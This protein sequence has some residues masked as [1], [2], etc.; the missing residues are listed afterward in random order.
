MQNTPVAANISGFLKYL[1]PARIDDILLN[2]KIR[3][4]QPLALN[5]PLEF[6]P[7]LTGFS[8]HDYYDF[9]I[10]GIPMPST[11]SWIRWRLVNIS[12]RSFGILSLTKHPTSFNMWSHYADGHKGFIIEL[13]SEFNTHPTFRA[14][15]GHIYPIKPVEYQDRFE[16]NI[17][18]MD[19]GSGFVDNNKFYDKLCFTKCNRW[20]D[21]LEYR[22]IRPLTDSNLTP[23][24]NEVYLGELPLELISSITFGAK[25]LPSDKQKI[26]AACEGTKMTFFQS[27]VMKD[28][29][30]DKALSGNVKLMHLHTKDMIE[31]AAGWKFTEE[32]ALDSYGI[33]RFGKVMQLKDISQLPYYPTAKEHVDLFWTRRK[34]SISA[35]PPTQ[36]G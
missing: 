17:N 6:N 5:D 22:L 9:V 23:T 34:A 25:M 19:D 28:E 21:E 27:I 32:L 33:E 10:D 7:I 4:T 15:D 8:D 2:H 26:V 29:V 24:N 12:L 1:P 3:F 16:I 14:K 13:A 18:E 36:K 30:D 11:V 20:K 35:K 31:G